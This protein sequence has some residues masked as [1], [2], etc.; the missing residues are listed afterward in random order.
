MQDLLE[1]EIRPVGHALAADVH[2]VDL[3]QILDAATFATISRAWSLRLVLR[4]RDQRLSDADLVR[5]SARFGEL[6][7]MPVLSS[8][9]LDT[10]G[11]PYVTVISNVLVDGKP[12]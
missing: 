3:S 1:I 6:D 12:I 2:G 10:T 7:R 11:S 9:T 5:F 4:F 8:D